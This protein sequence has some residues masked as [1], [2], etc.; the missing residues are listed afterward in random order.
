MPKLKVRNCGP[1]REGVD[2]DSGFI[3]FSKFVLLIGDQG[4]GKSTVAKLFSIFSWLEK[5]FYRGDYQIETFET[6]DFEDLYNNQ[7]N[8]NHP[9]DMHRHREAYLCNWKRRY[10]LVDA[11]HKQLKNDFWQNYKTHLYISNTI[12]ELV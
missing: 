3:S 11:S 4:T 2:T 6:A 8:E 9:N 1:I 10:S 12:H 5:A 7:F